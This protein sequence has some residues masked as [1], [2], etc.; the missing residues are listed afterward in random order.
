M[1]AAELHL[2]RIEAIV[3]EIEAGH[4][5]ELSQPEDREA[6]DIICRLERKMLTKKIKHD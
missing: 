4:C 2:A 1:T 5:P 3:T 6:F